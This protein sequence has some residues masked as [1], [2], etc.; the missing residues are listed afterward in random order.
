[1]EEQINSKS[2]EET[3]FNTLNQSKYRLISNNVDGLYVGSNLPIKDIINVIGGAEGYLNITRFPGRWFIRCIN[4]K[5]PPFLSCRIL[6]VIHCH[7]P[8]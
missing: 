3:V 6:S 2:L 8:K 5:S 1:M 7:Q 4:D